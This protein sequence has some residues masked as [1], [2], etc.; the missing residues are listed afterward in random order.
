V[1]KFVVSFESQ[2]AAESACEA[3]ATTPRA[4]RGECGFGN[5]LVRC[6]RDDG[7]HAPLAVGEPRFPAPDQIN[8]QLALST[9]PQCFILDSSRTE[10]GAMKGC[11]ARKIA[12]SQVDSLSERVR[13]RLRDWGA[14][15]AR[16]GK[17]GCHAT[18]RASSDAI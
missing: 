18:I 17:R 9:T 6:N 10:D 7:G 12:Y 15:P 3:S 1:L 13:L 14:P 8:A 2:G 5:V 4:K 16:A 11:G